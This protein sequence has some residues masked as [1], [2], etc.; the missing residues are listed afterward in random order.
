MHIKLKR[1]PG[2]YLAG[3]MGSGKSTVGAE[4]AERLGWD[5]VD[6]DREIESREG[7]RIAAIFDADG[8]P[9]FRTLETEA[10]RRRVSAIECG[11]PTVVALGGGAFVEPGNYELIENHGIT[12]WID[13][14]FDEI[15][16][17]LALEAHDRPLARDPEKFRQLFESR[18][19]G[20]ERA[21]F[22]VTGDCDPAATVTAIL[23]LPI[24]K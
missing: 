18:R 4:L 3:F 19:A 14:S 10:I 11:R 21:D 23:A 7:R 24:W 22:R 1:S 5:F 9:G 12:V 16:N 8:E 13:C 20:Y 15:K 2:I 17:R 6:L